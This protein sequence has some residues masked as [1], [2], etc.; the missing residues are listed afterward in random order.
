MKSAS[1]SFKSPGKH[2]V[3]KSNVTVGAM[4]V[5]TGANSTPFFG[6]QSPMRARVRGGRERGAT[7]QNDR[8]GA[9]HQFRASADRRRRTIAAAVDAAVRDQRRSLIA[10][11]RRSYL[12]REPRVERCRAE[13]GAQSQERR[14]VD[15]TT[16]PRRNPTSY[17]MQHNPIYVR[18]HTSVQG[19]NTHECIVYTHNPV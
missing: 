6:I 16:T 7:A 12:H 10:R 2:C 4:F 1:D 5:G 14:D 13:R 19:I 15:A 11:V 3:C 9:Q 17:S 18:K 8:C